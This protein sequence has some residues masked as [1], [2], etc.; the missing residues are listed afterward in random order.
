MKTLTPSRLFRTT[1]LLIGCVAI[2]GCGF[3]RSKQD[4]EKVV[5][6][7]FQTIATNGYDSAMADYGAQFFQ[8]TSKDAWSKTLARL[9]GKLGAYQSYSVAG[10]N[11]FKNASTSGAGTT[12][13]LQCQVVYSKYPAVESFTLFKGVGDS[14]YKIL[15]HQINSDGLLNE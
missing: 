2:G 14:E 4:A 1:L 15:G 13:R 11:V 7:H 12:V 3:T 9:G 10:W 6:R 8:K 5:A